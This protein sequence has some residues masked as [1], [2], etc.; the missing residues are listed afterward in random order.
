MTIEQL[1]RQLSAAADDGAAPPTR[2]AVT[3]VYRI[4]LRR[5][6]TR[7]WF[8]FAVVTVAVAG[9]TGGLT[10]VFAAPAGWTGLAG[11]DPVAPAAPE[12]DA[13]AG[14]CR[15]FATEVSAALESALPT[16]IRWER[17]ELPP[18]ADTA[19]CGGGGLFWVSFTYDGERGRLGFEGGTGTAETDACDPDR[20]PVRCE[21]ID[22]GEIGHLDGADEYGVLLAHGQ[23][24]F[25]LGFAGGGS[26]PLTTEQLAAAARRIAER[27]R[28]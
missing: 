19:D 11:A 12:P 5:R 23:A 17:P 16:G 26:H 6:R 14:S 8:S 4:G 1:Q 15:A 21:Q 9:A 25:F 22:G 7:R 18:G 28:D 3:E 10:A 20:R 27:I 2:V 13:P 24:F